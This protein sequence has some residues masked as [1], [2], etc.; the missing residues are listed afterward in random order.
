M[1]YS[2]LQFFCDLGLVGILLVA[3][4]ALS[5][6]AFITVAMMV[7]VKFRVGDWL[8]VAFAPLTL[9][10]LFIYQLSTLRKK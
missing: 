7:P 8:M 10:C 2:V 3:Y 5:Y 6:G 1:A 9:I 4:A